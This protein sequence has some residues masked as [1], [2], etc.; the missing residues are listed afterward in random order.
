MIIWL[1]LL[2]ASNTGISYFN[3]LRMHKIKQRSVASFVLC[4]LQNVLVVYRRKIYT[5]ISYIT[6]MSLKVVIVLMSTAMS[7]TLFDTLILWSCYI[8]SGCR[9]FPS[10]FLQFSLPKASTYI[11]M[12]STNLKIFI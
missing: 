8:C 5:R 3:P 2:S 7:E 6:S 9:T 11:K 12:T 4:E 1:L 10:T